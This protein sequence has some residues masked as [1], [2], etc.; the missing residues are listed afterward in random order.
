MIQHIQYINALYDRA[1]IQHFCGFSLGVILIFQFYWDIV[2]E[3]NN[4]NNNTNNLIEL[5]K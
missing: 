4:K 5:E 1:Y 2:I 3:N